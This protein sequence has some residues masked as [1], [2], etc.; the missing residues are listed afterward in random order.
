M[1]AKIQ[2]LSVI[3]DARIYSEKKTYEHV[4]VKRRGTLFFWQK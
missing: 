1:P 4:F 2:A 3:F